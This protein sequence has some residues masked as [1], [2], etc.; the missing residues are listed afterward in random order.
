ML[1]IF[2][3]FEVHDF[4]FFS[5]AI[6]VEETIGIIKIMALEYSSISSSLWVGIASSKVALYS[7]VKPILEICSL[8]LFH[9]LPE[10]KPLWPSSTKIRLVPSKEL[11]STAFPPPSFSS[12]NLWMWRI[13]ISSC[14]GLDSSNILEGILLFLIRLNV[15]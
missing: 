6:K 9:L 3:V 11:T 13:W 8:R 4:K 15:V 5:V 10:T 12:V 1:R 14:C 7:K 2:C